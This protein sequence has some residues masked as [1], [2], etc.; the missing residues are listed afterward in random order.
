MQSPRPKLGQGGVG[1][2]LS[3]YDNKSRNSVRDLTGGDGFFHFAAQNRPT[4][5]VRQ[6]DCR[7]LR[8]FVDD[9]TRKLGCQ[10]RGAKGL[11]RFGRETWACLRP[12]RRR[13]AFSQVE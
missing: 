4:R 12:S 7:N 5:R 11:C 1:W 2:V 9:E 6:E 8:R 10:R 13:T 3:R